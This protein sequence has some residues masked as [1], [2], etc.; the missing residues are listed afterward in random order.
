MGTKKPQVVNIALTGVELAFGHALEKALIGA[1]HRVFGLPVP[2]P[3]RRSAAEAVFAVGDVD[4]L[5][6]LDWDPLQVT[7]PRDQVKQSGVS[8]DWLHLALQSGC[9]QVVGIGSHLEFGAQKERCLEDTRCRPFSA[10]GFGLHLTHG[11]GFA[12]AERFDA[13]FSWARLFPLL[14]PGAAE[15]S[16]LR[17][18]ERQL[19][20]GHTVRLDA[21]QERID[22]L[23]IADALSGLVAIIERGQSE[24]YN[25]CRGTTFSLKQLLEQ[26]SA[27][28]GRPDQ[29]VF[30]LQQPERL[31]LSA[32]TDTSNDRLRAL[33]WCPSQEEPPE[34][35]QWW[36]GPPL[37]A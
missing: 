36:I 32:C 21:C 20:G 8:R 4:A 27:F 19:M 33:G 31:P 28:V 35:R 26:L 18:I 37:A 6:L 12:E 25:V 3:A 2:S 10:F 29:L 24:A 11:I 13:R 34:L 22:A 17:R 9:R 5:V 16:L 7:E 1:G 15:W 23:G 30:D 14:T